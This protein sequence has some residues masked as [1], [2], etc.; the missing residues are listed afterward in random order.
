MRARSGEN[1]ARRACDRSDT[2]SAFRELSP[3]ADER[4]EQRVG[5]VERLLRDLEQRLHGPPR[6]P[7]CAV[8]AVTPE[9]LDRGGKAGHAAILPAPDRFQPWRAPAKR[10]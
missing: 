5:A 8:I 7:A 3:C 4:L 2:G 6:H 1:P 10:R 9:L